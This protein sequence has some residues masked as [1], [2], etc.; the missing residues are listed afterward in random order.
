[1]HRQASLPAVFRICR[2]QFVLLAVLLAGSRYGLGADALPRRWVYLQENLQVTENVAKVEGI[3]RRAAKAGYNGIVLA[4]YKLSILDRVPEHYFANA[5]QF[6]KTCDELHLEIIPTVMPFGYSDGLLAHDPNLAEALPCRDV[7][8]RVADDKL[9][10][11]AD[12]RNLVPGDFELHKGDAFAGWSFQDEPGKGTF[13]DETIQ[14]GGKASLR[15][16]NPAGATGNRRVNKSLNV[17]PWTQ[18]HA[19]SWIRTDKFQSAGEVRMFALSRKGR[20]LSYSNLGVKPTQDWTEHHIVFNSLENSEVLFYVGVWD[21]RT[22]KLW[23]DDVRV[24]EEPLVNLV[25]REGCPLSV[26]ADDGKTTYAEGKD[27]QPVRDEK[28][29]ATPYAGSFDVYHRPPQMRVAAGSRLHDGDKLRVSYYHAVTIY[30]NQMPCSLSDPKVFSL[31]ADQVRRVEK[32]FA[33]KTYFLSHDEIRVANWS[34]TERAAGKTAGQLLAAN[35]RKCVEI[36]RG[37]NPKAKLCIWSDMFDPHHNAVANFYLVNGDLAGS[38]EGLPKD[39]TIVNWNSGKA[40]KSLRF[41]AD[42]GHDQVLAGYY[43]APPRRIADWL[44]A[45]RGLHGIDGVMYTTWR[46]NFSDLEKFAAAAWGDANQSPAAK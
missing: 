5:A 6:K 33:P 42:R 20:V 26:A 34:E 8:F 1:M 30:D 35:V 22:G 45:G 19:S 10:L 4:D 9:V 40:D 38:W 7:P 25:R 43:D 13:A 46:S 36:V 29:G 23:L 39:M 12:D 21:C 3:L 27:Y 41:F 44:R 28:L 31:A 2:L 17:R 11:D 16:E 15:I 14:H 24:R 37:V 32:L 18:F